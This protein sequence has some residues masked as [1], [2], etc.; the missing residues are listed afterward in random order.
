M[1]HSATP[2]K[3]EKISERGSDQQLTQRYFNMDSGVD[4]ASK[5]RG[6]AISAIFGNQDSLRV[7]Y[8]KRD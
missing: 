6:G 4:P 8:C 5:F 2:G 7:H 3:R 1:P